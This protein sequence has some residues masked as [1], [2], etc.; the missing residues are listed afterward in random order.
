MGEDQSDRAAKAPLNCVRHLLKFHHRSRKAIAIMRILT[1][2]DVE[3]LIDIERAVSS[4]E[5]AYIAHSTGQVETPLR[6]EFAL[7]DVNGVALVMPG[8]IPERLLGVKM[9]GSADDA[10]PAAPRRTACVMM[11]WD[12]RTLECRGVILSEAFND[13]RTAAGLAA[14]TKALARPDARTHVL[15]GAGKLSYAAVR[16][17]SYVRPIDRLIIVSRTAASRQKLAER[18]RSTRELAHLHVETDVPADEAA[19]FA[20]IATTVTRAVDPVFDGRRLRDGAHV[21]LGGAMRRNE[22]E[23]DDA[24]A[25]RASMYVD[26]EA[27]CRLR[28]GDVALALDNG[29]L[30]EDRL[31]GE[32]GAVL[33]GHLRG[34]TDAREITVFK[35]LGVAA[36]DL[37]LAAIL[38]DRAETESRGRTLEGTADVFL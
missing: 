5:E 29:S 23:M 2:E 6:T 17:I 20:D 31:R 35:S 4:A 22:R 34:R 9:V 32:I 27:S 19:A 14:A 11:A 16:C 18:V 28:A 10:D 13:Y 15:Y 26:C 36:Q 24:A 21:N 12:A 8:L 25:S 30:P 3:N 1:D 7:P 37:Y 33:A 38:F